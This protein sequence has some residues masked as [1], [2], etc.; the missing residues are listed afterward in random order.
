MELSLTSIN[1]IYF[2]F[3]ICDP[4]YLI[5]KYMKRNWKKKNFSGHCANY[6]APPN[7]ETAKFL[8]FLHQLMKCINKYFSVMNGTYIFVPFAMN[9]KNNHLGNE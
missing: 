2:T 7:L 4:K 8:I 5:C 9:D 6:I 3:D 1:L